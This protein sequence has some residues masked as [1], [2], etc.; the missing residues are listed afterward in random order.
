MSPLGHLVWQ[1]GTGRD[2]RGEDIGLT[3]TAAKAALPI[4]VSSFAEKDSTEDKSKSFPGRLLSEGRMKGA[5]AQ[6]LGLSAYDESPGAYRARQQDIGAKEKYGKDS[7]SLLSASQRRQV[8]GQAEEKTK[9]LGETVSPNQIMKVEKAAQQRQK[10]VVGGLS[11]GTQKWL[12]ENNLRVSGYAEQTTVGKKAI[13]LANKD[14]QKKLLELM[15]KHTEQILSRMTNRV[16]KQEQVDDR[17]EMAHRRA[18][19]EM[20]RSLGRE[21]KE[22]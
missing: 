21:P 14:E 16:P 17:V 15:T 6:Y 4:S 5:A 19:A 20:K 8:T 13:R 9:T 10:E 11:E 22:K 7:Y 12:K 3:E 18:W 2:F 1:A